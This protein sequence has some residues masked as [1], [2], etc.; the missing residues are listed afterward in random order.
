MRVFRNPRAPSFVVTPKGE[1]LT[2]TFISPLSGVFYSLLI[3][4]TVAMAAGIFKMIYE[5]LTREL[6]AV[7]LAWN[8]FNFILLISVLGVLVERKQVREQARLPANDEVSLV[9]ADG[10]AWP[11]H[12]MDLSLGGA[13]AQIAG[14]LS[15]L[16]NQVSLRTQREGDIEPVLLPASILDVSPQR[17]QVRIQF[18]RDT[19]YIGNVIRFVLGDSRRWQSFQRRRTRPISYWFGVKHVVSVSISPAIQH[20]YLQSRRLWRKL[21]TAKEGT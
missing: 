5:P 12:L 2:R 15:A 3:L 20:F 13:R 7:V 17:Q 10:K 9:D 16:Q 4:V 6:T 21:R 19:Q 8:C 11:G 14:D 1:N 18:K